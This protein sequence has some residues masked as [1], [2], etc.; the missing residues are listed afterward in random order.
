MGQDEGADV[1]VQ[2]EAIDAVTGGQHQHGRRAVEREAGADLF[3]PGCRKSSRLAS[4]PGFGA[5]RME[6]IGPTVRLTSM[7]ELPSSGSKTSRYLPRLQ[8]AGKYVDVLHFLGG[9][10]AQV[11]GPLVL[12]EHDVVAHDIELLLHFA[13]DIDRGASVPALPSAPIR[14]PLLTWLEMILIAVASELSRPENSPEAPGCLCS[15][16]MV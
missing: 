16:S 8:W 3:V 4:W 6:K 5:R 15:A 7:F 10:A 9:H 14:A 2:R 13:L 1:A 11:A 12:L